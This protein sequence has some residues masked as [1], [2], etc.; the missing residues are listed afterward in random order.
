MVLYRVWLKE[1]WSLVYG[2]CVLYGQ[3]ASCRV[4]QAAG[5]P[6]PESRCI[7][8]SQVSDA[9]ASCPTGCGCFSNAAN[10]RPDGH[11]EKRH[12]SQFPI[13]PSGIHDL[14]SLPVTC[15][16]AWLSVSGWLVFS[17]FSGDISVVGTGDESCLCGTT[18]GR[19]ERERERETYSMN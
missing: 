4:F 6:L 3:V 5:R 8:L 2:T 11:A 16:D 18:V 1:R 14:H 15:R 13:F 10:Q 7:S 17:R 19:A 9:F 12:V